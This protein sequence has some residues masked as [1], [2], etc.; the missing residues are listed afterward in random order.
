MKYLWGH[1]CPRWTGSQGHTKLFSM[2]ILL[3]QSLLPNPKWGATPVESITCSP[4]QCSSLTVEMKLLM[5][6]QG[7]NWWYG[8]QL[9]MPTNPANSAESQ[10]YPA[11]DVAVPGPKQHRCWLCKSLKVAAK[12]PHRSFPEAFLPESSALCCLPSHTVRDSGRDT[13]TGSFSHPSGGPGGSWDSVL[14]LSG[15]EDPKSPWN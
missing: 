14:L 10:S 5:A 7:T 8:S 9:I 4:G 13:G 15:M 12:G 11:R 2:S 3:Y 6:I 1:C